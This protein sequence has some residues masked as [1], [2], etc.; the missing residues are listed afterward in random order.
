MNFIKRAKRAVSDAAE[1][2]QE[3]QR[4]QAAATRQQRRDLGAI[5]QQTERYLKQ[6]FKSL[7]LLRLL[8]DVRK[9]VWQGGSITKPELVTNVYQEKVTGSVHRA[10]SM[11]V[12]LYFLREDVWS[13]DAAWDEPSVLVHW[14]AGLVL[15]TIVTGILIRDS[16][17]FLVF[18]S[19][20]SVKSS[21]EQTG[22]R[23]S[24]ET[25]PLALGRDEA[26]EKIH[27]LIID[28]SEL[29]AEKGLLPVKVAIREARQRLS[30]T[31]MSKKIIEYEIGRSKRQ[32]WAV[33]PSGRFELLR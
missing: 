33:N 9:E 23:G 1:K 29:R 7:R 21:V 24:V 15:E 27:R 3:R 2:R 16:E 30:S 20:F 10:G 18:G 4:Q 14:T 28:D 26:L 6:E 22:S 25:I 12:A 8:E 11:G 32:G 19:R 5:K 31:S 13:V 17:A